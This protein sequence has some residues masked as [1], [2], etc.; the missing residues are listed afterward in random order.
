[1]TKNFVFD[2]DFAN[3]FVK[4]Q[5]VSVEEREDGML[6]DGVVLIPRKYEL[7]FYGHWEDN[8]I[9]FQKLKPCP[10]CGG[11]AKHKVGKYN[12]TGS[13]GDKSKDKKWHGIYCTKCGVG[14]P[15]RKY[16]SNE[17]ARKHWNERYDYVE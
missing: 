2:Q 1:M 13:Y 9:C 10:F 8:P 11:K 7:L 4:G 12:D 6:I 16:F 17:E 3:N 14:Q 15:K 5:I